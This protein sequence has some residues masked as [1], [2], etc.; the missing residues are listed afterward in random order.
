MSSREQPRAHWILLLLGGAVVMS[1]LVVAGLT[2]SIGVGTQRPGQFGIGGQGQVVRGPVLDGAGPGR[3]LPDRTVALTFEDGPDPEWTPRILDALARHHAHATFFVVG[4]RV[5]EHPELVRRILAEGHELGLHGFTHRDLTALPEWQVRRELD[6]TRDAVARATGRDIRLFRPAYSSTPAQVDART[7]ALIAAAGRWGYRTVL[8][9]LDTRDWQQPGVPAIAVAG[10]PLGDNGA[11]VGLHD[12]GGDRSQTLRALDTLLPTLHRRELR[13]VTVSEGLGEPIPV[14]EAGSG[15]RARGAALAVVQ[16]GSTLVADLLFVLLVTATVLALTRMA[17]QAACAWQHSRRRRKAIEDVGHTPAVS[18][19]VPAHNEAANI[20]AVIESLVATA[21]PDLEVIVVDDGSTDDTADIV[22]RLGLPGVRV[23]RQANAGKASALQAGIDAAR[24]DLVV[25]VDGDTILE[26]ETLHLMVRPFRDTM[27]GAVAGNAK[28]ANRGGLLGRWQHLEYVIAFNL[29]RRVFEVASCMPTV[30]GALGAF[31]RTA[32]TAAGG[33][34]VATLAEDTDLTMAVCRAGWK[35]VYEDAACAWTEAPSSWQSLWRQ[36]YRWCYGTM[37]AMWKHRAAFRES[38]AAGKL[39][40]RGLSYLLLFQ[41]AQPILAPLVDVYLLYTLLF[42]PVTWTVVL[43]AT[44]HA[45]QFAVAAYAFRLDRED[46]GPLWTLLLQ[47]VVY[48]QLIYLVVIQ[49]AITALVGATL[50]WHQPARAGHAAALTTV[51]TQMIAQRARRD[52][53]KGPLWARLCVWGGVVLM[54]V[55][56]SGLIAG[57]VLAQRYEDAIG[58]ADLL[59][60]TATWHGA[61]AGTWELRGPLNILLVGVDWRKGQG[62][63]IR[64][65]TVMVLHVPATMDRAYVVSLPRDT[66]VDIPAT[67]GF[68]G[69]RDRLNAAF[70]YGAGA[71]QDRARGGRLLAETVRDLTGV[72]GF[73]GAAL[74]DFYGFM[75]VVRVMG[76]VDLCVDVD[77]TSIATGVVYRKGCG[78]MDAPSALDYVR[79][80]KTIATG[81]YARQR[82]QQQFVKA[83]VTEAR[84]QDL[85]RD[86]VK[87]DRVVRAAGNS[88]TVTT[89]PVG[90]PE[91]LFTLGRI[92]AERITLVRTSG[93]SVNDARGQY[94]GEALDPVSGA[95]FQAVREDGLEA[96]LAGHPGLVQRDG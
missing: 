64:A 60:A 82:H 18:V 24:H 59:G 86:P 23:I 77:T 66:L 47:Q 61:P 91:M 17:I 88:L 87:L 33:L 26:P 80:R 93:R 39:G 15:A 29:D 40:R 20:A 73:D 52:R 79:Q 55:S 96:F 6:L 95:M 58:H 71:E 70:A 49:S 78:R 41:I 31:R 75:E 25:L 92:P 5:D 51:R 50:R 85:V 8:S 22:E 69:G 84:R 36:R 81:D 32:L 54:G 76:G 7:M 94:L 63:L 72:A 74:V 21:Y 34:S 9:D 68:P 28:V 56:G 3:G 14:R 89:G 4:A 35:V 13:V 44:L 38:G 62:G 90:L 57:Q 46:A 83:L 1:A 43:W 11:I 45:A 2:G 12:G 48:R 53:R 65:D 30:P 27:V 16:S 37:Q 42:Q 10:A 19:I 67:P